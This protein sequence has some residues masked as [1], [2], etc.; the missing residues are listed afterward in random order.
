MSP[1][2]V[3]IG[4]ASEFKK[5]KTVKMVENK[6]KKEPFWTNRRNLIKTGGVTSVAGVAGCLGGGSEGEVDGSN[7][8]FSPDSTVRVIIPYGEGGGSDTYARGTQDAFQNEIGQDL[9]FDFVTG[10]G[11]LNGLGEL[12]ASEPDGQTIGHN[13]GPLEATP[14]LLQDPGF[15]IR[16]LSGIGV[17][18]LSTW[19]VVVNEEYEDEVQTFEDVLEKYETGEWSSVGVQPPGSSP[20][21]IALLCRYELDEIDWQWENRVQYDGT[22][23]AVQ[24]TATG[25]V[26]CSIV[27]DSGA[28]SGVEDGTVYPVTTFDSSGTGVYPDVSTIVDEGY[29][30]IDFIGGVWRAMWLPPETPDEI[31]NFYADALEATVESEDVQ[32]WVEETGNPVTFE[33]PE[34]TNQRYIDA[35]EQFQELEILDLVEEHE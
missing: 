2:G 35:F 20:D 4:V 21:I 8:G 27:T 26:P 15:D 14:Q 6:D 30:E 10:A 23:A 34:E 18:G 13:S 32:N 5:L 24:G 28:A 7:G 12:Y 22:G 29:P 11:G 1:F 3:V 31:V 9:Q 17:F 19:V 16:D 33:G 25:D